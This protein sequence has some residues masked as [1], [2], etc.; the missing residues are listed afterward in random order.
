MSINNFRY[1]WSMRK[2]WPGW[3]K[4]DLK[5]FFY[6]KIY[7]FNMSGIG[8]TMTPSTGKGKYVSVYTKGQIIQIKH[9]SG[10]E[11]LEY[12]EVR[13]I[14]CKENHGVMVERFKAGKFINRHLMDLVQLNKSIIF[15]SNVDK[16]SRK[17]R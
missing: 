13:I 1:R 17:N 3:L 5:A 15:A 8:F 14:P 12:D 4:R 2:Y 10:Y 9:E 11:H 7:G 6:S 16:L